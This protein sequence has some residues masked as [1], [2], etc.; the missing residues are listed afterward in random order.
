MQLETMLSPGRVKA[1]RTSILKY[2]NPNLVAIVVSDSNANLSIRLVSL[3]SGSDLGRIELPFQV[4]SSSR[5]GIALV[6]DWIVCTY[7]TTSLE[8]PTHILVSTYLSQSTD[9]E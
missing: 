4:D 3:Q 6:E 5:I 2:R 7:R 9:S 8:V 1:D